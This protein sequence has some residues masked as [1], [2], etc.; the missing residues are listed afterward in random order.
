MTFITILY[1]LY[2][3]I[4]ILYNIVRRI[5][6]VCLGVPFPRQYIILYPRDSVGTVAYSL[7]KRFFYYYY[8]YYYGYTAVLY[9]NSSPMHNGTAAIM[10]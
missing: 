2:L 8:H 9:F 10:L 3:Y 4:N 7:V 1:L 6:N 5:T